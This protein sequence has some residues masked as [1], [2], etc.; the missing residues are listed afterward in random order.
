[1]RSVGTPRAWDPEVIDQAIPELPQVASTSD[2]K[3]ISDEPPV[4][5]GPG[6]LKVWCGEK[7]KLKD[8]G[9]V[10]RSGTLVK[11]GRVLFDAG[12]T[13]P[14][15]VAALAERDE[16]LGYRKYTGRDDAS[17]RYH[18]IVDELQKNGRNGRAQIT[19]GGNGRPPTPAFNLT[20]KGNAERLV[21]HHGE[22]LRYCWKWHEWFVFDGTRWKVDDTGEVYRRAK[23]TVA[24]IYQEASSA[25]DDEQRKALAKH[26]MRSE[27]GAKIREMIHLARDQVPVVPSQFDADPWLLNVGNGTLNLQTGALREHRREDLITKIAPAEY[28]PDAAA[29]TWTATLERALPSQE[30]RQFF[31]KLCGYALTGDVS[32]HVLPVLYGTGA[33]GKSPS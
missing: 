33:N 23:A 29:P 2:P 22:D 9:G 24:S 20:E 5:L 17:S 25:T 1:M 21:H 32:E 28:D 31:K 26:A 15:I 10:D 27:S 19:F 4:E 30:L 16:T 18:D 7:P 13:R 8:G 3:R 14:A 12:A 6:P 11:I